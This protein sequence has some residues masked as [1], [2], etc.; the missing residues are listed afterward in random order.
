LCDGEHLGLWA[1]VG[2]V[3]V[4]GTVTAWCMASARLARKGEMPS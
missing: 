2:G 4:I 3:I 1:L